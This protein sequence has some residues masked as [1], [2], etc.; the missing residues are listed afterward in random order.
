MNQT[1][2]N[3]FR[4][5]H[6]GR[7]SLRE[8]VLAAFSQP[9]YV[10]AEQLS[11]FSEREW[12]SNLKWL[13]TSGLALYLL[14]HLQ[15]L[16]VGEVL[17]TKI[18]LRLRRNLIDNRARNS[19]L[20]TETAEINVALQREGVL[21]ANLKGVTLSPDAVPDPALR[22]QLDQDFLVSAEQA[23]TA[24][25]V[26]ERSG[27]MLHCV[28]GD[29]W[30]FKAGA[31][32][33]AH[34]RDLYKA[35]PQRSAELHLAPADGLLGRVQLRSFHG[36]AF[37]VLSPVDLYI[38]Q[39]MHLFGHVCSPFTR[40]SW[41]L[42]YRRH[43]LARG[44]DEMFWEELEGRIAD[45]PKAALALGLVTLLAVETFGDVPP[46]ALSRLIASE[47]APA[48]QLWVRLYGQRLLVA[49]FPGTKLYLLLEDELQPSS[50][51]A[52][53]KGRSRLIPSQRPLNITQA[54][55]EE[56][57][58]SRLRRSRSQTSY[59]LFRLRFHCVEGIRY[60]LESSRFKRLLTGLAH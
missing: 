23:D 41:L 39:A 4:Q 14:G 1:Q 54:E 34:I 42:E 46:K 20:L 2:S 48:V 28:S 19:G 11:G 12:K 55:P 35:K 10:V 5:Q 44:D 59:I 56:S 21:F 50:A 25:H 53:A 58:L 15:E 38:E 49:D 47:V 27:Y 52:A 8:A 3:P 37:P 18:V 36:T 43:M 26:L 13:D 22:C 30:E 33:V 45:E 57:V 16:G 9:P 60:V 6:R 40:T 31:S 17:P 29:T 7:H 32:S 24:A 51:R